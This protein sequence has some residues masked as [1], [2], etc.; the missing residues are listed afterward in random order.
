MMNRKLEVIWA[1]ASEDRKLQATTEA[2]VVL[3]NLIK[4]PKAAHL[5]DIVT[6]AASLIAFTKEPEAG[7]SNLITEEATVKLARRVNAIAQQFNE[8][9]VMDNEMLAAIIHELS[10]AGVVR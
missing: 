7:K 6:L 5:N 1:E 4:Y 2:R 8:G 10:E 9:A 3:G